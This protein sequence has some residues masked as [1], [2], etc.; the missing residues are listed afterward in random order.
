MSLTRFAWKRTLNLKG[1]NMKAHHL[2]FKRWAVSFIIALLITLLGTF[3]LA[4]A[5]T[6]ADKAALVEAIYQ[7]FNTGDVGGLDRA[8][9]EDFVDH[10][11]LPGT[12]PGREGLKEAVAIFRA[13]LPDMMI[14]VQEIVI[15]GDLV[16]VRQIT[17]GTHEGDFLG[18]SATGRHVSFPAFDMYRVEGGRVVESWHVEDLL[19]ALGQL[20]VPTGE[21]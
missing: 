10:M 19:S 4:Q 5:P 11:A 2:Q 14:D 9:S 8:V 15:E 1:H 16:A 18:V 3:S 17:T 21:D 13:G 20:G 12:R 7:A 6:R